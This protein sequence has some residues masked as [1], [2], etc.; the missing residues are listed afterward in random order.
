MVGA[1]PV[2]ADEQLAKLLPYF[3]T[4]Q[5]ERDQAVVDKWNVLT[6][7]EQ[8]HL[9]EAAVMGYVQGYMDGKAGGE[10][11]KDNE[12]V[13]LVLDAVNSFRDLYP[14]LA[15]LPNRKRIRKKVP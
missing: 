7:R 11:R 3:Q 14:V 13:R 15:A 5:Q 4:R 12:I 2:T 10:H 1:D 6:P 8:A 9:R